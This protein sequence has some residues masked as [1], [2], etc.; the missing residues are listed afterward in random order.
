M[1]LFSFYS[2]QPDCSMHVVMNRTGF[3]LYGSAC[4]VNM[5]A[6]NSHPIRIGSEVFARSG[7]DDSCTLACF[8][9]G[10]VWP[11]PD[12]VRQNQ[13]RSRLVLHSMIQAICGRTQP[14]L[15]VGNWQQASCILP[16]LGP[17][18]LA[19]QLACG[20]DVFGQNMTRPSRL[21]LGQFYT[22]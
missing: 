16:E 17:L 12:T 7:P 4:Q 15:K 8:R 20:L 22:I 11:K 18:I 19:H 5:L 3:L 2:S 10:S 21:D 1:G 9:A 6:P 14:G 13:I